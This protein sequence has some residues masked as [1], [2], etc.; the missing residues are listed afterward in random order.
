MK[1]KRKYKCN[2]CRVPG[3]N[4][5]KMRGMAMVRHCG[6]KHKEKWQYKNM[7]F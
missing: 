7:P 4:L 6:K 2:Y 3:N 5:R 1:K